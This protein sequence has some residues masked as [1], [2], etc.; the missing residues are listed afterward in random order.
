M[1]QNQ[2]SRPLSPHLQIYKPQIT[3][4]TSIFNRLNGIYLFIGI[5]ISCWLFIYYNYQTDIILGN[6]YQNCTKSTIVIYTIYFFSFYWIFAFYYYLFNGIRHLM[7]DIGKGFDIK[8][9]YKTAYLVIFSSI[10]LTIATI[11]SYFYLR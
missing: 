3:S 8:T 7:W 11:F 10:S 2:I 9:V 1:S 6:K 4:F 5:L